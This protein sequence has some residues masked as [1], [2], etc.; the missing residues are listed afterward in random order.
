MRDDE[1]EL[2]KSIVPTDQ[3]TL[4]EHQ[5]ALWLEGKRV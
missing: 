1:K 2:A 4:A 3:W 5:K